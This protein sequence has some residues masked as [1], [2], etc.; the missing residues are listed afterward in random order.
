MRKQTTTTAPKQVRDGKRN[1]R[2]RRRDDDRK[3]ARRAKY[4]IQGRSR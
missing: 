3:A 2:N 1:P 4:V